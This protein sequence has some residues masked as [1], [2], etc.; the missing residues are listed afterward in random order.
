MLNPYRVL[1]ITFVK[2]SLQYLNPYRV[3]INQ[4]A[5]SFPT[6]PKPPIEAKVGR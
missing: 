2:P 3:G 4:L 6:I 1:A 5:K